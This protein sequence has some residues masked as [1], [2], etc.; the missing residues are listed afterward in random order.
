MVVL[1]FLAHVIK[2]TWSLQIYFFT[3]SMKT[4]AL[5]SFGLVIVWYLWTWFS[6]R[7]IEEP[8]YT[9]LRKQSGY[10]V[11]GYGPRILAQTSV[12]KTKQ[13][14]L[15]QGFSIIAGYI[16][17]GNTRREK[18]AMTAPVVDQDVSEKIAMTVPVLD[19]GNSGSRT[20][21]FVMPSSYTMATATNPQRPIRK[22]S[23]SSPES[24]PFTLF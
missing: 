7:G 6:I 19:S 18:I 4:I 15:S 21:A 10:E 13:R 3:D 14:G 17:G 5:I 11:R 23:F 8:T 12:S 2:Y 20:I 9:V 24:N 16:F 1:Q 22:K